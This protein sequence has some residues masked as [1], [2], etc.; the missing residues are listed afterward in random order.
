MY[1]ITGGLGGIGFEV[2]RYLAKVHRARLVLIGRSASPLQS[3]QKIADLAALGADVEIV[4]AD[5]TSTGQM[6]AAFAKARARFGD[7]NG[8]FHAAGV[9]GDSLMAVKHS[10]D[11]ERV[12]APKVLGTLALDAAIGNAALDL[13][14]LFSSI[15]SVAGLA[16]QADYAAANAFLD[17]F[18]AERSTR[19]DGLTVAINW[20][21]WRDVGMVA[22]LT[23]ATG[24]VSIGNGD[25][26][27]VLGRR[28]WGDANAELYSSKLSV[29]SQWVIAEHRL[30]GG[31][32]LMPGT[33][34]VEIA[35]AA[36]SMRDSV[37]L[38]DAAT[39]LNDGMTNAEFLRRFG[40]TDDPRF[41]AEVKRIDDIL[42]VSALP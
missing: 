42:G 30:R 1:V 13:F 39:H 3:R 5:V 11:A 27:P 7:V 23:A 14:V 33:G 16:G 8:V 12:L 40:A 35:A 37:L 18:A 17:A 38:P 25:V 29:A 4:Q 9:L 36:L 32:A 22:N 34:H 24:E 41:V 6:Q 15:S 21:A 10:D 28:I 26:H 31:H 19:A 20:S 2:A